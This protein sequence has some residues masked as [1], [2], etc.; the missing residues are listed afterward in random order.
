MGSAF[1]LKPV[2]ASESLRQ[3]PWREPWQRIQLLKG[4]EGTRQLGL[5]KL[6]SRRI[7]KGGLLVKGEMLFCFVQG[8]VFF[9]VL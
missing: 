2:E 6:L 9:S 8:K 3:T 5:G 7:A 4:S 1:G